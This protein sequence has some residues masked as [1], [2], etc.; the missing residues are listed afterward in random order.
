MSS[1]LVEIPSPSYTRTRSLSTVDWLSESLWLISQLERPEAASRAISFSRL[2]NAGLTTVLATELSPHRVGTLNGWA[3]TY[4]TDIAEAL[5]VNKFPV[6]WRQLF[7][8]ALSS[9]RF[10]A[11]ARTPHA[12]VTE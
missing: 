3:Q 5:R 10:A 6:N 11:A 1:M 12:D 2:L 8:K 9:H 4:R 7:H